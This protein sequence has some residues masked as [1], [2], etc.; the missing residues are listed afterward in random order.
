MCIHLPSCKHLSP[1]TDFISS[2][3]R[4]VS[5]PAPSLPS[6]T[7]G[8]LENDELDAALS[9]FQEVLNMEGDTKGEWGFKALKQI[10][11]VHYKSGRPTDML[12][13]HRDLLSYTS[14]TAITKNAAEKKI[15]SIL[16]Y[17]SQS[18]N[19]ALLQEF[20]SITLAALAE[21]K[22]ERLWFKASIKL[23]DLWVSLK[24]WSKADQVLQDLHKACQDEHG[25]D[26]PK[27][28]TQLLEV[29]AL[30]I[31]VSNERKDT[32]KLK[33]LYQRA[34]AIKSAVPHPRVLGTILECGG[35]MHMSERKWKEAATDFFEAFK[36]F[37]EAGSPR[38]VQCL[39][40]LVLANMLMESEVD[41]FDSQEARPYK[42]DPEVSAMTELVSAYQASNIEKFEKILKQ[43]QRAIT[44][45]PFIAKYISDLMI[46]LRTAVVLLT[47]KPYTRVR[48]DHISA[49]LGISGEDAQVLVA[50]LILDGKLRGS[51]DQLRG[52][53]DLERPGGGG[54]GGGGGEDREED[55][56]DVERYRALRDWAHN[57][58]LLNS[59]L[60][61]R[62][63]I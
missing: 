14:S 54:N 61:N 43:H 50:G 36:A 29:Y 6:T 52:V 31:R 20:Y 35:K 57:L 45:D 48:L 63:Y 53:L 2:L 4:H 41:P 8:F 26:D 19:A 46:K 38:R 10:I 9:G 40:Y 16:D 25:Q 60:V 33:Q 30:Q 49:K 24:E 17:V 18:T 7:T 5:T 32:K 21:A 37:D 59:Q 27:K 55:E 39:K 58:T 12:N 28:G 34:L 44:D 51:I 13:A 3:S 15:N 23:A 42:S 11:K 62:L 1:I 22:N 56:Q 47:V